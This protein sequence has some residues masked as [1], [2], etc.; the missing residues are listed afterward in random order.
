VVGN[1]VKVSEFPEVEPG[2]QLTSSVSP[3]YESVTLEHAIQ[4]PTEKTSAGFTLDHAYSKLKTIEVEASLYE[5]RKERLEELERLRSTNEL[6]T[7]VC[8]FGVFENYIITK[9]APEMTSGSSNVF[10][11]VITFQEVRYAKLVAP[12][13]VT[14]YVEEGVEKAG[15]ESPPETCY[16][17]ARKPPTPTATLKDKIW[18]LYQSI[19]KKFIEPFAWRVG[20]RW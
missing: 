17:V 7:L 10:D 5:S 14:T 20:I 1:P 6:L 19:G 12:K 13:F 18:N 2:A 3:T 16:L 4:A 15:V 9:I 11:V 8:D